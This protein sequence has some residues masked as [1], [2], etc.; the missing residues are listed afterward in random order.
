MKNRS[1]Q[2]LYSILF[3]HLLSQLLEAGF[4]AVM[5]RPQCFCDL[6][7]VDADPLGKVWNL[8]EGRKMQHSF[9]IPWRDKLLV[10]WM[11]FLLI[12]SINTLKVKFN[13]HTQGLYMSRSMSVCNEE[14]SQQPYP[15][16]TE[17]S[18]AMTLLPPL[19]PTNDFN[20]PGCRYIKH[21][22][23]SED[24]T[25]TNR[26]DTNS[27]W[28]WIYLCSIRAVKMNKQ[29]NKQ[30]FQLSGAK[31]IKVNTGRRRSRAM[32]ENCWKAVVRK[33]Q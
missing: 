6:I 9:R 23:E 27:V 14:I 13:E 10:I 24:K 28:Y 22:Y 21:W 7:S 29:S 16:G 32:E 18:V 19:L 4:H 5:E 25:N 26:R 1:Y 12:K 30:S 3:H 8:G 20:T 11:F 2:G 31:H 17:K 15:G 33:P